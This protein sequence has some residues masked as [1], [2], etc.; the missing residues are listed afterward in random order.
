[1]EVVAYGDVLDGC[2][3]SQELLHVLE[4]P[5]LPEVPN[6]VDLTINTSFVSWNMFC[7]FLRFLCVKNV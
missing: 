6:T 5:R 2:T 3:A 4:E 7:I 1:V